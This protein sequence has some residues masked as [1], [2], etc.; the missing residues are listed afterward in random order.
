M[1]TRWGRDA[2]DARG[3]AQIVWLWA[4]SRLSGERRSGVSFMRDSLRVTTR[5]V[6]A[7]FDIN[8]H[9]AAHM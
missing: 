9:P 1:T 3:L 4:L 7:A 8:P 6:T 2:S 5:G